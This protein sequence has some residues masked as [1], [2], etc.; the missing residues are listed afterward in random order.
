MYLLANTVD[1]VVGVDTHKHTHTAALVSAA[2]AELRTIEAPTTAKGYASIA[3]LA[4][5]YTRERRAWAVEGVSSYGAGLCRVLR[6]LGERVIEID[7][8]ARPARRNGSKTDALDAVRARGQVALLGCAQRNR[9]RRDTPKRHRNSARPTRLSTCNTAADAGSRCAHRAPPRPVRSPSVDRAHHRTNVAHRTNP[10]CA[11]TCP[12]RPRP[13]RRRVA[14]RPAAHCS[15]DLWA[16]PGMDGSRMDAR[17]CVERVG[18]W[19]PPDRRPS[20]PSASEDDHAAQRGRG[21]T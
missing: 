18:R 6:R 20:D 12:T 19:R 16:P 10:A 4:A 13:S 1:V 21:R 5:G 8:P 2:G 15:T 9:R 14:R 7:H 11:R 3:Q 17:P